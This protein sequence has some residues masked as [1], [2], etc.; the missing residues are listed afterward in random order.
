MELPSNES[1]NSRVRRFFGHPFMRF[2]RAAMV[3]V[4][5]AW[6]AVIIWNGVGGHLNVI[7]VKASFYPA[8]DGKTQV[9]VPPFG[10]ISADT[11]SG[12]V[13]LDIRVEQ[14]YIEKTVR[15]L[16]KQT[17]QKETIADFEE[18]VK[19]LSVRLVKGTIV[20]AAIGA[21]AASIL[22][23]AGW[24]YALLGTLVG[25][26]SV[27]VPVGVAV[28]TYRVSAFSSPVYGG[29]IS[30]APYLLDIAQ[31]A[32]R[33]YEDFADRIPQITDR[34]ASLYRGVQR[35]SANGAEDETRG[36]R[37]LLISDLHNNPL[38]VRYT[39][40]LARSYDVGLVLVA[41][42]VS[43]LGSPLE[44]ELVDSW[45][46]Y[47]VP[48]VVVTGNHDSQT[49]LRALEAIPD[50]SVL[51]DGKTVQHLGLSIMG[52]GDPAAARAQV[53]DVETTPAQIKELVSRIRK[54]LESSKIPDI[55][56]V[57]NFRAARDVAG[58]VPYIVTGHSHTPSVRKI[59][60]SIVINPGSAGAEGLRYL[61][62]PET[63]SYTAAVLHFSF[64]EA[65]PR[66]DTVDTI[67]LELPSGDFRVVRENIEDR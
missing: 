65:Q 28:K 17:P 29:E 13:R 66:L 8:F 9:K 41:G 7:D 31:Q 59:Q 40:E 60:E 12:P 5:G 33:G 55:L 10:F 16:E 22:L 15:W 11:H 64:D 61:T 45:Q 39:S 25:I 35:A 4:L 24:R 2:I 58:E 14:I 56:M 6:L 49:V 26:L 34:L 54:H 43:D 63:P 27:T 1:S 62:A 52:F 51:E 67:A 44:A 53:G 3:G 48:V 23:A 30:R 57:H 38:A 36:V 18:Q 42:D 20:V 19:R 32:W 21:L 50:V 47:D 37:V 46:Q